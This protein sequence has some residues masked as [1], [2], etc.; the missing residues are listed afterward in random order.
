MK[1]KILVSAV[2]I[3]AVVGLSM[4]TTTIYM[5]WFSREETR[6]SRRSPHSFELL[7]K[8][9]GLNDAQMAELEAQRNSFEK[10][11]DSTRAELYEKRKALMEELKAGAPDTVRIDDL[12]SE[13]G[14]LQSDLEKKAIRHM[15]REQAIL[16]PEQREKFSSM[17]HR[18]F[19]E[20]EEMLWRGPMGE[21]GREPRHWRDPKRER[22]SERG[23]KPE[24]GREPRSFESENDS[25]R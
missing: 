21:R 14:M 15:L 5:R 11:S 6:L 22:D 3:L 7:R 8:E 12:V 23:R 13:I 20:R 1:R 2:V 18:H 10:Q 17:F 19:Q 9:L 4:L 24:H 25:G 16:T